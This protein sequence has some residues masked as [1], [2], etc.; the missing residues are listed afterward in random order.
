LATARNVDLGLLGRSDAGEDMM[1]IDYSS[2]VAEG[3][4]K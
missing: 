4:A 1:G 2:I 3:L